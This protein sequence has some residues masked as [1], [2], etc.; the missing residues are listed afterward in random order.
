M[1][2]RNQISE[3]QREVEQGRRQVV[4]DRENI[5]NLLKDQ[6]G[7]INNFKQIVKVN[8]RRLTSRKMKISKN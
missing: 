1:V 4:V 8:V 5:E 6:N 2:L 3:L 7:I